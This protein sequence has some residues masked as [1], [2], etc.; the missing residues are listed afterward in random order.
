[1]LEE[2]KKKKREKEGGKRYD[3]PDTRPLR[4]KSPFCSGLVTI[5]RD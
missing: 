1:M 2:K 3:I 5:T 4:L